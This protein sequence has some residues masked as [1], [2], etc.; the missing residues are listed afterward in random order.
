MSASEKN[1]ELLKEK[2]QTFLKDH[3]DSNYTK[4]INQ[5]F[6]CDW[7]IPYREEL[8]YDED[9][10]DDEAKGQASVFTYE[11]EEIFPYFCQINLDEEDK[12]NETVLPAFTGEDDLQ[13]F[14]PEVKMT[15]LSFMELL[16]ITMDFPE[17]AA[18]VFNPPNTIFRLSRQAIEPIYEYMTSGGVVRI[19]KGNIALSRTEAIVT[20]SNNSLAAKGEVD[21]QVHKFAGPELSIACKEMGGC[22]TGDAKISKG[23]NLRADYVIHA[24]GPFY[25][26]KA[27]DE[28]LLKS[29]YIKSLDLAR[30]EGIKSISFPLISSGAKAFPLDKA[31]QIAMDSILDGY[32]GNPDYAMTTVIVVKDDEA[33][34]LLNQY[35]NES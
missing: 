19:E 6:L 35:I 28:D 27:E 21:N 33:Y 11:G 26:G 7:W 8:L 18:I 3:N 14:L 4:V 31:V 13:A 1:I 17:L 30:K 20:A 2:I 34:D 16:S 23:F 32:E 9:L 15:K 12:E 24:V 10:P 22:E 5:M 29:S 25:T